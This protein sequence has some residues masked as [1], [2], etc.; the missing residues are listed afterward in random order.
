[1]WFNSLELD[2]N[3]QVLIVYCYFVQVSPLKYRR[4]GQLP[5]RTLALKDDS[6]I[7]KVALFEHNATMEYE[8]NSVMKVSSVY[9]KTIISP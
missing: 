3:L 2:V 8:H 9:N 1:M 5:V 6:G 7:V 4:D